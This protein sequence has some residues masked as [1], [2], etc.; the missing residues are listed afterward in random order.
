MLVVTHSAGVSISWRPNDQ[1]FARVGMN[2]ND[3]LY[4]YSHP[5]GVDAPATR[6]FN[7]QVMTLLAPVS[8]RLYLKN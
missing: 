5:S 3:Q 7:F 6:A 4:N 8:W 2:G 1:R